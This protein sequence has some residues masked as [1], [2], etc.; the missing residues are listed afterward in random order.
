VFLALSK[1]LDLALAPLSWA[2]A[3]GLAALLLRSRRPGRATG[4]GVAA[5]SI[6]A[7]FSL[8]P[9][10]QRLVRIAEAGAPSTIQ[11]G[12]TYDAVIVL[13][14]MIDPAA[15]RASGNVELTSEA[16]RLV[17]AL[18]LLRSGRARTVLLSGG[19]VHALPGEPSE[20]DSL[21]RLLRADGIADDRIVIEG[22]SRNT[23]ENAIESARIVAARGWTRLLLVTSAWHAPRALGCF[24]AV[25]LSPDVLPVD[26]RLGDGRN[27][28]WLPRAMYLEESTEV[29]RELAGRVVYRAMG[30]AR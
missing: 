9:V 12:V 30:W 22:R 14:G 10:A 16:D 28:T 19:L 29:L 7:L 26:R 18:L 2:L 3:L 21:A 1:V 20:A 5:L 17:E 6:L 24:R 11:P 15:T 27:G 8:Q 13:G 23:R 4:L 25:G